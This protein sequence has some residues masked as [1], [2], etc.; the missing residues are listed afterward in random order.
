MRNSLHVLQRCP[1]AA[2]AS[3][4]WSA[5]AARSADGIM[6]AVS[7]LTG[8]KRDTKSSGNL[9]PADVPEAY[10]MRREIDGFPGQGQASRA[11]GSAE[12]RGAAEEVQR[13]AAA[14]RRAA[15]PGRRPGA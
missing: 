2:R 7:T 3:A 15:R 9:A 14:A 6:P 13:T 10:P 12:D 1:R 5:W 8:D 11:A 4:R